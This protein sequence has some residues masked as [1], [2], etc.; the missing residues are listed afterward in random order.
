MT[1]YRMELILDEDD[2]RDLQKEF[3]LRQSRCRDADG[4]MLPEG[5]SNL[6]GAL[7]GEIVR[8]LWDYRDLL[9]RDRGTG[10]KERAAE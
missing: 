4:V 8:G 3:S 2:Y 10:E 7:I 1:V 6:P 5:E 9:N